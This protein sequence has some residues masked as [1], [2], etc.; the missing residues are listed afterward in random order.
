MI[1]G[2]E[3]ERGPAQ[4]PVGLV[5]LVAPLVDHA[6]RAGGGGAGGNPA[7]RVRRARLGRLPGH[8]RRQPHPELPSA[9]LERHDVAA[10][11]APAV[12]HGYLVG[13]PATRRPERRLALPG[14]LCLRGAARRGGVGAERVCVYWAGSLGLY[15]LLR[16][17]ALSPMA[18]VLAAAT[19]AFSGAMVGQLVHLPIV[20][21]MGWIPLVI[22]AQNP[23]E[24]GGDG[25][26][27]RRRSTVG[28]HCPTRRPGVG[29]RCSV[30]RSASSC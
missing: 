22:L 29:W 13:Q 4:P 15:A 24:L 28:R 21:G 20:Q 9:G 25:N 5:A 23:A 11:S 7:G 10:R 26:R 2:D 14:D 6:R 27:P 17:F 8:H 3:V 16:Q 18:S 1:L 19:Y 30:P 12:E